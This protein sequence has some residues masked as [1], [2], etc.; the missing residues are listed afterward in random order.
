MEM[1]VARFLEADFRGT[2][3]TKKSHFTKR[4]EKG[5]ILQ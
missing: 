2:A 4:D 5:T 1:I 3:A